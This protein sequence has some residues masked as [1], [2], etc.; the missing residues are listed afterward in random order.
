MEKYEFNNIIDYYSKLHNYYVS[1]ERR[2]QL[3]QFNKLVETMVGG[4]DTETFSK[5]VENIIIEEQLTK[6]YPMLDLYNRI[7][8]PMGKN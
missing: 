5:F 3:I 6:K 2:E 4:V 1:T 8:S 7:F